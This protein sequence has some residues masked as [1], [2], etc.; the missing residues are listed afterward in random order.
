MESIRVKNPAFGEEGQVTSEQGGE[1]SVTILLRDWAAG[2]PEAR[3]RLFEIVYPELR[4]I[5]GALFRG[6]NANNLLQPTSVVNELFLKLIRQRNLRFE[7]RGHFYSL[8]ARLMRR[9]LIDQARSQK[10]DKRDGGVQVPLE[11]GLAWINSSPEEIMDVDRV[12]NEL[13]TLDPRKT[14]DLLETSKATVDRDLRFAR[15]WLQDRLQ[16][17]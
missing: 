16:S 5:A 14:A 9:I 13:E 8:S 11:D 10:R 12:L 15:A 7:D 6:E 3:D 2:N 4:R 1:G 17:T